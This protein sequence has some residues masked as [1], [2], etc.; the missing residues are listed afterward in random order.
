MTA[1]TPAS[2]SSATA[3]GSAVRLPVRTRAAILLRLL[4]IQGSWN[5]EIL[6]GNGIAFCC[7]PALR[8]F[9]EGVPGLEVADG[10]GRVR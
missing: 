1:A 7:E 6:L 2:S 9:P 10:L 3:S 8:L 4:A 5:Y